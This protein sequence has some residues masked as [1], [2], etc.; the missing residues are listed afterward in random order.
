MTVS[1]PLHEELKKKKSFLTCYVNQAQ[2]NSYM[3]AAGWQK[4]RKDFGG[5]KRAG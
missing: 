2:I 4:G 1:D 5:E 3:C